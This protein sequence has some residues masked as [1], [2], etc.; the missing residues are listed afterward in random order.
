MTV[1]RLE[2]DLKLVRMDLNDLKVAQ[3][4]GGGRVAYDARVPESGIYKN[5][6][7]S[8]MRFVSV[9][10]PNTDS[11]KNNLNSYKVFD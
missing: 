8:E 9:E 4:N 10:H 2:H 7:Y 6:D 1:D 5:A 11:Q 3:M